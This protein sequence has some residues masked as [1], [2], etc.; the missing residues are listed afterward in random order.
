MNNDLLINLLNKYQNHR[1]F[2]FSLLIM[3][4]FVVNHLNPFYKLS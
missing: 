2:V 4:D 3:K 1:K